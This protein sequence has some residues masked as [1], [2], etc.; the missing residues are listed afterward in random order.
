MP[1]AAKSPA[2]REKSIASRVQ[3]GV[4]ARLY[5]DGAR[6]AAGTALVAGSLTNDVPLQL[7]SS[8][9][10]PYLPYSGDLDEV[11]LY[12]RALADAEVAA[13]AASGGKCR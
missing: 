6:V 12:G 10:S 7:G 13:L 2:R 4:P 9:L 3:P 11:S 5:L 1:S 8:N